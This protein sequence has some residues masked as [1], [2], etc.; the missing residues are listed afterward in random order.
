MCYFAAKDEKDDEQIFP[1][2]K[3]L[4]CPKPKVNCTVLTVNT[5]DSS[6]PTGKKKSCNCQGMTLE[7]GD[8]KKCVHIDY[9]N[10]ESRV[11]K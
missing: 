5:Q 4:I 9:H 6:T 2:E 3:W 1:L 7:I 8:S 11:E 10:H